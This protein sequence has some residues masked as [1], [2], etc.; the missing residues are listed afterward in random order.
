M[1]F[2]NHYIQSRLGHDA[3]ILKTAEEISTKDLNLFI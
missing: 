3:N 1:H 2:K